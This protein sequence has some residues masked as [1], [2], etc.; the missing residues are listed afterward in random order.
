MIQLLFAVAV[1]GITSIVAVGKS[2]EKGNEMRNGE[3]DLGD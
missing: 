1:V 2:K 3:R